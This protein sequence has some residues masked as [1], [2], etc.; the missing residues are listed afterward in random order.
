MKFKQSFW[1]V[2]IRISAAALFAYLLY[3]GVKLWF[4]PFLI[5]FCINMLLSPVNAL[6][7]MKLHFWFVFYPLVAFLALIATFGLF[8]RKKWAW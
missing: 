7:Y 5:G 4:F 3:T 2:I 8:F 1:A 6:S